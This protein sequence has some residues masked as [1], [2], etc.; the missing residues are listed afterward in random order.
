MD[1]PLKDARIKM[2]TPFMRQYIS[3]YEQTN[4]KPFQFPVFNHE[5]FDV[6]QLW[7]LVRNGGG[8]AKI[9]LQKQW[10]EL[11]RQ[12][13][14]PAYMTNLSTVIKSIFE[15]YL[16]DY[17]Q[18]NCPTGALP[19][20]SS[21]SVTARKRK[22]NANKKVSSPRNKKI[23]PLSKPASSSNQE[24]GSLS[25]K[26]ELEKASRVIVQMKEKH[27]EDMYSLQLESENALRTMIAHAQELELEIQREYQ[28][29]DELINAHGFL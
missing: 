7:N 1:D 11:G 2:Q 21:A 18:V 17:E 3:W 10:A 19:G 9:T 23:N 14:P 16:L 28:K 26:E 27:E 8:S 29:C 22:R 4:N 13:N 15:R 12:F 25:L 5:Y 24:T 20:P 6:E